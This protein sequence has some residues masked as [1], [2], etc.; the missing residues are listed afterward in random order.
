METREISVR[1]VVS[2]KGILIKKINVEYL[3]LWGDN[4]RSVY[5]KKEINV[6]EVR[7]LRR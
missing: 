4:L 6:L 1:Q 5:F 7:F 2:I 3:S